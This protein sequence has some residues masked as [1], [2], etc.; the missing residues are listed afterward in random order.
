MDRDIDRDDVRIR[1]VIALQLLEDILHQL[2]HETAHLL[3]VA[4]HERIYRIGGYSVVR[5]DRDKEELRGPAN[6]AVQ[7]WIEKVR[8]IDRLDSVA[9]PH[10]QALQRPS[11]R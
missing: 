2:D 11:K 8:R 7:Q 10:Q 5:S 6:A 4:H 3:R 1:S 9:V